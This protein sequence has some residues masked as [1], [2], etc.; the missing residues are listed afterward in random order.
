M[1]QPEPDEPLESL[2]ID[3]D[4]GFAAMLQRI[5]GLEAQLAAYQGLGDLWRYIEAMIAGNVAHRTKGFRLGEATIQFALSHLSEEVS[6][7]QE[8]ADGC[9]MRDAT[10]DELADVLGVVIHLV[11]LLKE[12]PV[13]I[14]KR[15]IEKLKLRFE[16]PAALAACEAVQPEPNS[17]SRQRREA[18]LRGE[19]L[20]TF[21]GE[22]NHI[23]P[24]AE[25][26][27]EG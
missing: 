14:A 21:S 10:R 27:G 23:A 5:R 16:I 13:S 6:E 1:T 7:L 20:P 9:A 2:G 24:M 11:I 8:A 3:A 26:K 18:V 19:E 15:E 17:R 12:T 4:S 22:S 25:G